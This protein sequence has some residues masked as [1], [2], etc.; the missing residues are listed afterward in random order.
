MSNLQLSARS[1]GRPRAA[2]AAGRIPVV[3]IGRDHVSLSYE[4]AVAEIKAA[5]AT[6]DEHGRV[7]FTAGDRTGGAIVKKVDYDA[8]SRSI[9]HVAFQEVADDDIVKVE[10]PVVVMGHSEETEAKGI[11]LMHGQATV[12]VEGKIS[13]IPDHVEVDASNLHLGE[14][15]E[16]SDITMPEGVTLA[17]APSATVATVS[18]M[19]EQELET[20]VEKGEDLPANPG[21][22]E[23]GGTHVSDMHAVGNR[24]SGVQS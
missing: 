22:S 24:D 12:T 15:L 14:H 16:A 3:I 11:E 7:M 19:G 4:A 23:P 8:L 17:S 1:A 21:E 2:R 13:D 10:V 6:P 18:M 5:L 9:L 20:P